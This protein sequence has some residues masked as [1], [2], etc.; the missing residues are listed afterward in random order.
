VVDSYGD[1]FFELP[2]Y[3]DCYS[4]VR[5]IAGKDL[6]FYRLSLQSSYCFLCCA[7][8]FSLDEV[9][10]VNPF[11]YLLSYCSAAQEVTAY[12]SPLC[13]SVFSTLVVVSTF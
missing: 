1:Y 7:E 10:F 3:S 11:S 6:T 5:C 2:V 9:P 13:S 12:A 4:T 8:A